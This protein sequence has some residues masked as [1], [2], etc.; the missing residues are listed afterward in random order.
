[1]D[2]QQLLEYLYLS[3][4]HIRKSLH[5]LEYAGNDPAAYRHVLETVKKL[6]TVAIDGTC[7]AIDELAEYNQAVHVDEI[8][9]IF[10]KGQAPTE[11]DAKDASPVADKLNTPER[12]ELY[13]RACE[14]V[15]RKGRIST[16]MIQNRLDVGYALAALIIEELIYEEIISPE[17]DGQDFY[18]LR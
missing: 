17:K 13:S 2:S 14:L 15:L 16:D 8:D 9:T 4:S 3:K 12:Q 10:T 7:K 1:M 18:H 5:E 11:G 6:L